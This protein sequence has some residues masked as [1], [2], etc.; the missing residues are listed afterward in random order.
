MPRLGLPS[1]SAWPLADAIPPMFES[2][3]VSL[4]LGHALNE[5]LA[6]KRF[7]RPQMQAL[8]D[9]DFLGEFRNRVQRIHGIVLPAFARRE[10]FCPQR[11]ADRFSL[12]L[13][14]RYVLGT[15]VDWFV[16]NCDRLQ[17]GHGFQRRAQINFVTLRVG[18]CHSHKNVQRS[19]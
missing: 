16:E 10:N 18:W 9:A 7:V 1:S 19:E 13:N 8:A 12:F 2:R 11:H 17:F 6:S 14:A 5:R 3:L 15:D 4:R